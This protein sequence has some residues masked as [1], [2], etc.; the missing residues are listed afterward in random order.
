MSCTFLIHKCLGQTSLRSFDFTSFT[1]KEIHLVGL[2][3]SLAEEAA[4][5]TILDKKKKKLCTVY[6]QMASNG[7]YMVVTLL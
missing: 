7:H 1:V 6:S 3:V 2:V 5:R 4:K